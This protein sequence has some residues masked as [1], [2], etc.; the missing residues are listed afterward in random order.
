MN[1]PTMT[2][3]Q[4]AQAKIQREMSKRVNTSIFGRDGQLDASR[5]RDLSEGHVGLGEYLDMGRIPYPPAPDGSDHAAKLAVLVGYLA[6]IPVKGPYV[7]GG[8]V[9]GPL[10]KHDQMV[11]KA[12]AHL[13]MV[14]K[15]DGLEG[16]AE[17]SA[18]FADKFFREGGGAGTY[19]AKQSVR[20]ETCRL[21]YHHDRPESIRE[22]K[23]LQ[24]FADACRYELC[25]LAP[26]TGEGMLMLKEQW[27]PELFYTGWAADK[28]NARTWMINRGWK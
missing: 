10:D 7:S 8:V 13:Y 12:V 3:E 24:V 25:R 22:D 17:R 11:L 20:E 14:G 18:A 6:Q 26:N 1:Q 27:K 9:G 23:R 21:I 28:A 4:A 2:R 19:W 5:A 15:K 16:Y